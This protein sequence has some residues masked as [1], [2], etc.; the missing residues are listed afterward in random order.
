MAVQSSMDKIRQSMLAPQ[1][2]ASSLDTVRLFSR[3]FGPSFLAIL[4]SQQ[5]K[6]P[7]SPT[8]QRPLLVPFQLPGCGRNAPSP[9]HMGSLPWDRLH[10]GT[11]WCSP[12]R[13]SPT[14]PSHLGR[15]STGVC[16]LCS[17]RVGSK[18]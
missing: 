4:E 12:C 8:C 5:P 16:G 11:P 17:T 7:F 3:T 6:G 18:S 13:A 1:G 14:G 10:V 9:P 15:R 2:L